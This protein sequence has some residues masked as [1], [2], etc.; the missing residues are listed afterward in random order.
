[1]PSDCMH[2]VMEGEEFLTETN[3]TRC[4][5]NASDT[6]ILTLERRE[7][8]H[9]LLSGK[10]VNFDQFKAELGYMPSSQLQPIWNRMDDVPF[11]SVNDGVPI[12]PQ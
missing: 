12:N 6:V 8:K 1:M 11:I 9:H 2:L 3:Y 7:V 5:K 10:C 4:V